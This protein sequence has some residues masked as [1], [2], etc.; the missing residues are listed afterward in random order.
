[1]EIL[2]KRLKE[3]RQSNAETQKNVAKSIEISERRYIDLETGKSTP[4][5]D[6]LIKICK[7]FN[8]SADYLL[9]LSDI[10]ERRRES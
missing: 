6:T 9:G 3:L 2:S 7:Y 1:M 10:K 5:A 8:V 4:Y